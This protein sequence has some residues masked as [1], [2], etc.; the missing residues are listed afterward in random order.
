MENHNL[1]SI[2]IETLNRSEN[3][4]KVQVLITCRY[5]AEYVEEEAGY[6]TF[7]IPSYDITFTAPSKEEGELIAKS[8]VNAFLSYWGAERTKFMM[9]IK[10]LGFLPT[11]DIWQ[12]I[13][14]KQRFTNGE[15]KMPNNAEKLPKHIKIGKV[16]D[17]INRFEGSVAR[18]I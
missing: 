15:F 8:A 11:H 6:Y 4:K 10:S 13:M 18:A 7:F 9:R 1:N 3:G 5:V 14:K 12:S 2:S 16:D 17:L